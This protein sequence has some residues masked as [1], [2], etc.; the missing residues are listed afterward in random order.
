M[1]H[2]RSRSFSWP[3]LALLVLSGFFTGTVLAQ[4][5]ATT[6]I[7]VATSTPETVTGSPAAATSTVS[8]TD[9]AADQADRLETVAAERARLTEEETDSSATLSA[10]RQERILNLAANMSNRTDAA[11]E[12]LERIADRLERR[13]AKLQT[14]GQNTGTARTAIEIARDELDNATSIIEDIDTDVYRFV[15]AQRPAA[16]WRSVDTI[17]TNAHDAI[18]NAHRTLGIALNELEQ[19]ATT[20]TPTPTQDTDE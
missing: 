15:T 12:R 11:I 5:P 4:D 19:S 9:A 1:I 18:R 10:R 20:P 16:A 7:P 6:T 2:A 17:Y 13:E 14:A 8:E 3:A